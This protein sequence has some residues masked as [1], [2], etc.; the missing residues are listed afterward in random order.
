MLFNVKKCKLLRIEQGQE[1]NKWD[2]SIG[3]ETFNEKD[4]WLTI[5]ATTQYQNNIRWDV[6]QRVINI[7]EW[8]AYIMQLNLPLVNSLWTSWECSLTEG[9][10]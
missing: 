6:S 4:L 8:V 1:I 5:N 10:H 2:I 7:L 9:V 3:K